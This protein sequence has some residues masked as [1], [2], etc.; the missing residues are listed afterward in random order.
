MLDVFSVVVFRASSLAFRSVLV[1]KNLKLSVDSEKP[2]R[3]FVRIFVFMFDAH[4]LSE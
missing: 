1:W 3:R 2:K 4:V